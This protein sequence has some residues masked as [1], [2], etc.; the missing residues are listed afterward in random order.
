MPFNSGRTDNAAAQLRNSVA[1][2]PTYYDMIYGF[3]KEGGTKSP[4][5]PTLMRCNSDGSMIFISWDRQ[6]NL[7]NFKYYEVQVSDDGVDWYSIE[8]DGTDWNDTLDATT[9]EYGNNLL[10]TKIPYNEDDSGRTLSYRVRTVTYDDTASDWSNVLSATTGFEE[11]FYHIYYGGG[12]LAIIGGATTSYVEYTNHYIYEPTGGIVVSGE[13]EIEINVSYI[14]SGNGTIIASGNSDSDSTSNY[15]YDSG[16]TIIAS[17]N[18][19][20]TIEYNYTNDIS[21]TNEIDFGS[22]YTASSGSQFKVDTLD[23]NHIVCIYRDNSNYSGKVKIGTIAGDYSITFGTEYSY[24]PGQAD[25][26]ELIVLDDSHIVISYRDN[27]GPGG[28]SIVGVVNLDY[29]ITFGTRYLF[30]P[31]NTFFF[32]MLKIDSNHFI[33]SFDADST[34]YGTSIIGT[35]SNDDEISFTSEYIF[36]S[37]TTGFI[38]MDL[39]DSSR[40]VVFYRDGLGKAK[41]GTIAGD[42]SITFG[43]AADIGSYTQ[44]SSTI[45]MDNEHFVTTTEPLSGRYFSS[46]VGTIDG[47]SITFSSPFTWTLEYIYTDDVDSIK[48]NNEHF[49]ISYASFGVGVK[50]TFARLDASNNIVYDDSS[51]EYEEASLFYVSSKLIDDTHIVVATSSGTKVGRLETVPNVSV[52]GSAD[53]EQL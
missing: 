13:V 21:Y 1:N 43:S 30:D 52:S 29:S 47:T 46:Y 6:Y 49:I 17:G 31:G 33:I 23:N 32:K 42:Y 2:R 34:N 25:P 19:D 8:F 14:Y 35:I 45:V 27:D 5:A 16:G 24:S 12:G 22:E 7:T 37:D 36:N 3:E 15:F 28:Y 39:I 4:D 18:S 26:S 51:Y 11:Y 50:S 44:R 20:S 38:S 53:T 9:I 10:H 41:I 48:V 40:F